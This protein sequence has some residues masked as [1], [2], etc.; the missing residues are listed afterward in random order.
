MIFFLNPK[1]YW[2]FP[3]WCFKARQCSARRR[4]GVDQAAWNTSGCCSSPVA[5]YCKSA[6]S[7]LN[8]SLSFRI[9]PDATDGIYFDPSARE[10]EQDQAGSNTRRC[11]AGIPRSHDEHGSTQQDR[12]D[13]EK[14]Y[15]QPSSPWKI[16]V[17]VC[18]VNSHVKLNASTVYQPVLNSNL[19]CTKFVFHLLGIWSLCRIL[20]VSLCVFV[21]FL[22]LD[23]SLLS[24]IKNLM[25]IYPWIPLS[26]IIIVVY[27][28]RT[29]HLTHNAFV[30]PYLFIRLI[31]MNEPLWLSFS[32][33]SCSGRPHAHLQCSCSHWHHR[34]WHPRSRSDIGKATAKWS[35][36]CHPQPPS[37]RQDGRR[38]QGLWEH[39][40]T[41]A[42]HVPWN[43]RFVFV[44]ASYG[45]P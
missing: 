42:R 16:I 17:I 24:F 10:V 39:V 44:F 29:Q 40:W 2:W 31:F 35:L 43:I 33:F 1:K 7:L 28:K 15:L 37:A 23:C 25:R 5:R 26:V 21:H 6:H 32:V 9:H 12:W 20:H 30:N 36:I 18:Q 41:H 34:L 27:L 3:V 8:N 22:A 45:L 4:A 19:C 13:C 38:V 14:K 11:R